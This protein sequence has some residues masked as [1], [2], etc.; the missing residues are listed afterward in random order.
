MIY[1]V[2]VLLVAIVAWRVILPGM[3]LEVSGIAQTAP[4]SAYQWMPSV[5]SMARL[6][7]IALVILAVAISIWGLYIPAKW[8]DPNLTTIGSWGRNH[9]FSLLLLWGIGAA[10]VWLNATPCVAKVLQSV[11]AGVVTAM[12]VV[13]PLWGWMKSAPAPARA[14]T[15]RPENALASVAQPKTLAIPGGVGQKSEQIP[16]PFPKRLVMLGE[17]YRAHCRY[18]DGHE[19]SFVPGEKEAPCRGGDVQ[20]V[21]AT[22]LKEEE[23]VVAYYYR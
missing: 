18:N 3:R 9:W 20:F 17:D 4:A 13:F 12:L 5:P 10:L 16:V 22:N 1:V 11:L 21:Y 8:S 19:E 6:T 14:A 23:N 2:L 7:T 15:A